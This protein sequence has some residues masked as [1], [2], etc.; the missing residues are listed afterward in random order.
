M[1]AELVARPQVRHH[2]FVSATRQVSLR[3][4]GTNTLWISFDRKVWF[5]VA[6]G[7]SWDDRL[8]ITGFWYCTQLGSA[9]FAVNGLS[10]NLIEFNTPD[11]TPEECE[12]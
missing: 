10:M 8:S 2:R 11:P 4:T 12:D 9:S 5:D 7:T 1:P 6:A 3:N